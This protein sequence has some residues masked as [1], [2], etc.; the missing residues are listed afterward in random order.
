MFMWY[1]PIQIFLSSW[2]GSSSVSPQL[3]KNI[4]YLCRATIISTEQ[5]TFKKFEYLSATFNTTKRSSDTTTRH[6]SIFNNDWSGYIADSDLLHF[7]RYLARVEQNE[8]VV[9]LRKYLETVQDSSSAWMTPNSIVF[10]CTATLIVIALG[11]TVLPT[12]VTAVKSWGQT[13][14]I[15]PVS[16]VPSGGNLEVLGQA[17]GDNEV[18]LQTAKVTFKTLKAMQAAQAG[19][20]GWDTPLGGLVVRLIVVVGIARGL[21]L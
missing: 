12:V 1:S 20:Q 3:T 17:L 4:N 21:L 2:E 14:P 9:A 6:R 5:D 16:P 15:P 10:W 8:A 7:Q 18:A 13:A 19:G 11:L